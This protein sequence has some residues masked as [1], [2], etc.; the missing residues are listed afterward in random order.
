MEADVN[1]SKRNWSDTRLGFDWLLFSFSLFSIFLE[2]CDDPHLDV[3]KEHLWRKGQN[4]DFLHLGE[5][6]HIG[7]EAGRA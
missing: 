4:V 7:E 2:N 3:L 5:A 1:A 6:E